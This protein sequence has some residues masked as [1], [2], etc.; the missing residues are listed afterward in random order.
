ME[1]CA[2]TVKKMSLELGGNAPLIVFEDAD[3]DAAIKGAIASK[4]RNSGQTC[5]CI[6]RMYIHDAVYDEFVGK[7]DKAVSH[8]TVGNGND[9]NV[10]VGPLIDTS[11]AQRVS[12]LVERAQE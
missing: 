6:N 8:F 7:L 3:I 5:I 10:D 11:S 12:K 4:Y 1:Q 2:S 9:A